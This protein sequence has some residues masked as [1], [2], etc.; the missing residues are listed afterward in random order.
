MASAA[1]ARAWWPGGTAR[2]LA[3]IIL[4][5]SA[6]G[7]RGV[8]RAEGTGGFLLGVALGDGSERPA[9]ALACILGVVPDGFFPPLGSLRAD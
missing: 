6:A 1:V 4:P 8:G 5:L 3:V 7:R 2:L 9:P